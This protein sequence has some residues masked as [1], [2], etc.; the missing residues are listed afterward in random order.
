MG[1]KSSISP[2][3]PSQRVSERRLL[4][5][6]CGAVR[7]RLRRKRS[8][9]ASIG[10]G[11]LL[12]SSVEYRKQRLECS[13]AEPGS[14]RQSRLRPPG[15]R[16]AVPYRA[17]SHPATLQVLQSPEPGDLQGGRWWGQLEPQCGAGEEPSSLLQ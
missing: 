1:P 15:G 11:P 9:Y 8:N 12:F 3:V 6:S 10:P 16:P 17:G 14:D 7:R 4:V 5:G 13:I 2:R